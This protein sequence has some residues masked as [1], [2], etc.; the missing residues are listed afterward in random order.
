MIIG[1][2]LIANAFKDYEYN[3]DVLIFASGVSN[4]LETNIEQFNR[5]KNLLINTLDTLSNKCIVYFSSIVDSNSSKTLY[6]SHKKNMVDLIKTYS[7][8][9]III[10]LPQLIGKSTNKHTLFNFLVE[11]IKNN[12]TI[13]VYKNTYKS[14]IDVD[15]VKKIF[16]IYYKRNVTNVSIEISYIERLLVED[17]ITIIS[18]ELHK[19]PK[20]NFVNS[21][22]IHF[23]ELSGDIKDILENYLKIEYKGY[24][25]KV[26][27]KYL[28]K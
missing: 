5:E 27:K 18:K 23:K 14:I 20:I 1:H 26:I 25:E 24:T 3:E 6:L 8:N 7:K 13:N 2:G 15:D 16:D 12:E 17:I 22:K 28:N 11:K 21:E 4:S 10:I 19:T 9:Y